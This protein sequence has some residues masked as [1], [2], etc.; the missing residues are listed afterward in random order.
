MII[1]FSS[2]P[3]SKYIA[4]PTHPTPTPTVDELKV[5]F[6]TG[7]EI[8]DEAGDFMSILEE[9]NK[10]KQITNMDVTPKIKY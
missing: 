1:I 2:M 9:L 10:F 5:L 8:H 4:H 3:M 6:E 7:S